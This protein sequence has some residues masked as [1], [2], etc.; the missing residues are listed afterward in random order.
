[1]PAFVDGPSPASVPANSR[2]VWTSTSVEVQRLHCTIDE[3]ELNLHPFLQTAF[4]DTLYKYT[5]HGVIFSTHSI[6]LARAAADRIYAFQQVAEGESRVKEFEDLPGFLSEFLGELSFSAY[7]ELGFEKL[8]LVEGRHDL[9]T[10]RHLL[11]LYRKD[12][13]VIP[14]PL[15]GNT[16]INGKSGNAL[17]ELKRICGDIVALIDSERAAAGEPLS[18]DRQAF[19]DLCEEVGIRCTVLERRAIE[20]YLSDRAIKA[21]K[22][23]KYTELGPYELLKN[24]AV[25]WA[26]DENW[27]IAAQMTPDELKETDLGNFLESV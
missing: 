20:N 10:F 9:N 22:G 18:A 14:L 6:G 19:V 2:I 21:V 23:K 11:R 7:K 4:L 25:P 27:Q 8:L 24:A 13:K 15:G 16:L 17:Q 5:T 3:P 1:M 26:K 12:A